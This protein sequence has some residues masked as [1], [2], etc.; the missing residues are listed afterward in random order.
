MDCVP[1][2]DTRFH[3]V[4]TLTTEEMRA[5]RGDSTFNYEL[6]CTEVCGKGHFSMQ[7]IVTVLEPEEWDQWFKKTSG[8]PVYSQIRPEPRINKTGEVL[9]ADAENEIK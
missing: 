3:F 6:A 1:G 7:K 8:T 2:M 5:I 9:T 4:P